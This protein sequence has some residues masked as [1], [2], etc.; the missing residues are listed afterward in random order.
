MLFSQTFRQERIANWQRKRNIDNTACV[1][2]SDFRFLKSEFPASKT[3]RVN[4]DVRPFRDFL[5]ELF[6]L[7]FHRR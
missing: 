2:M 1:Q 7:R 5:C 6:E 4:R 3:V